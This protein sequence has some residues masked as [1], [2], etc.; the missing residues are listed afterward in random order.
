RSVVV[1]LLDGWTAGSA[2][3]DRVQAL[4]QGLLSSASVQNDNVQDTLQGKN[5]LDWFWADAADK[6]DRRN[7][8]IAN[9]GGAAFTAHISGE[10]AL[11]EEDPSTGQEIL[12]LPGLSR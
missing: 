5:G 7:N 11:E 3:A 4:L 6:L 1:A 2:Y 10:T 8:E 12:Y 9:D